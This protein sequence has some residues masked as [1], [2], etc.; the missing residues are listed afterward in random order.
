MNKKFEIGDIIDEWYVQL[1]I[2]LV[3]NSNIA[4]DFGDALVNN[5]PKFE[6][7]AWLVVVPRSCLVSLLGMTL[8]K[9]DKTFL[10]FESLLAIFSL[11]IVARQK[12]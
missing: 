12:V 3:Q 11:L 8:G 1:Y 4:C 2:N 9:L 10:A 6:V 7:T 5:L